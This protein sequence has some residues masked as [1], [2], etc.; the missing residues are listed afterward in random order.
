MLCFLHFL[1][2]YV[3]LCGVIVGT[4]FVHFTI[5]KN[6]K[7]LV[8]SK[9]TGPVTMVIGAKVMRLTNVFTIYMRVLQCV[10]RH[11]VLFEG[12]VL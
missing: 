12:L 3:I 1:S 9:L 7:L 10:L 6:C 5:M 11:G 4:T 2:T 8:P